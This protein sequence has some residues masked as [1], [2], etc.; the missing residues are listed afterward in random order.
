MTWLAENWIWV[1]FAA[2]FIGMHFF[3]HGCCSGS[4][5]GTNKSKAD[6]ADESG[7]VGSGQTDRHH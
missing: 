5:G 1:A 7:A 4:H 2:A 3:G 6:P